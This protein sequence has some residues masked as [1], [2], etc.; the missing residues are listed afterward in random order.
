MTDRDPPPPAAGF[1][2]GDRTVDAALADLAAA[3]PDTARCA[4]TGFAGLT[5]GNGLPAVGLRGLQEYLWYQLPEKY[6]AP[7]EDHHAIARGL[8]ALFDRLSLPRYAAVCTGAVTATVL[9]AYAT[10]DQR[11]CRTARHP[12]P[13]QLGRDA[14]R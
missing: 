9:D 6:W 14:R 10:T 13:A 11:G 12:R 5:W 3:D 1:D 8:G 7:V 4:E 2:T